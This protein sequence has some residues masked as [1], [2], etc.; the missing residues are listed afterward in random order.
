MITSLTGRTSDLFRAELKTMEDVFSSIK[1]YPVSGDAGVIVQNVIVLAQNDGLKLDIDAVR[2][3]AN[4]VVKIDL[5]DILDRQYISPIDNVGSVIL[6]DD[7]APVENFLNPLTG[8]VYLK[9]II[10]SNNTVVTATL[11][12]TP[13]IEPFTPNIQAISQILII[14]VVGFVVLLSINFI[15]SASKPR[16]K[17]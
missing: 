9:E 3:N 12:V 8:S 4:S 17:F 6:T 2:E 15:Y 10:L 1:I 11:E 16:F 5:N 13:T 14:S 7:F